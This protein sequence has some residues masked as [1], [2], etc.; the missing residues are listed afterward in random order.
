[1]LVFRWQQAAIMEVL[2]KRK[3]L[4][5]MMV[6]VLCQPQVNTLILVLFVNNKDAGSGKDPQPVHK[7]NTDTQKGVVNRP[8]HKYQLLP[9]L[10]M[11]G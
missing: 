2:H 9:G 8:G 10:V 11:Q 7:R 5:C 1:M 4:T 3:H 6:H